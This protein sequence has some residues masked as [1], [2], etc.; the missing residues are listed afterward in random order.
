MNLEARKAAVRSALEAAR[1]ALHKLEAAIVA[2]EVEA[3]TIQAA[4]QKP[5]RIEFTCQHAPCGKKFTV[6]ASDIRAGN[7][8]GRFC[9]QACAKAARAVGR[10]RATPLYEEIKP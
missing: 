3:E 5:C 7:K 6:R 4:Y 8:H 9:S 2:L 1:A 10:P